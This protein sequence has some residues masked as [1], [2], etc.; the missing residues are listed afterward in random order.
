MRSSAISKSLGE[1]AFGIIKALFTHHYRSSILHKSYIFFIVLSSA[2]L[3]IM[4]GGS[5]PLDTKHGQY[6]LSCTESHF[7]TPQSLRELTRSFD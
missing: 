4:A 5:E 3:P 7:P 6:V 1:L 2:T